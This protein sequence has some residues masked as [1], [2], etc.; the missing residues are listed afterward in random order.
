MKGSSEIVG[1]LD[2]SF[3]EHEAARENSVEFKRPG[4]SSWEWAQSWGQRAVDR[5]A[6]EALPEWAPE[7]EAAR[8][9]AWVSWG[10]GVALGRF[11]RGDEGILAEA[12]EGALPDGI[13][14]LSEVSEHDS[15]RH[16]A[17]ELLHEQWAQWGAAINEANST[18]SQEDLRT[19]LRKRFF[20]DVH[21]PMYENAPIY[22]PLSS[23][24]KTF[25]AFVSIHRWHAH[26]LER[27]SA[28]H[29]KPEAKR[30]EGLIADAEATPEDQRTSKHQREIDRL[31]AALAE[32]TAFDETIMRL[33]LHGPAPTDA[34]CPPREVNARY[35]PVLDDGT[36]INAA[37]LWEVLTPQWKYPKKWW[38]ELASSK[39]KKDYDWSQLAMRY[40]PTRVSAKCVDDP[41][42]AVAHHRFWT[43]HPERAFAWELRLQH[44]L[45]DPTFHIDEPGSDEARQRFVDEHPTLVQELTDKELRRRG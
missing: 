1:K 19:W 22:F 40:F 44:D 38:K 4:P 7:Y 8:P 30:V 6:G 41:S 29:L 16:P 27:L 21:R 34:K 5:A 9:E 18:K 26:T 32:L 15:L 17:C 23:P 25:V 39:G 2:E 33:A 42:L 43:L 12:P 35:E 36:M 28:D 11:G 14:F 45:D 37:A 10:V 20:D 31:T 3:S 24:K 13:L